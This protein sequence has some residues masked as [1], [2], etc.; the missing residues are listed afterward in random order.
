MH[1]LSFDSI[2][3]C[4]LSVSYIYNPWT[5]RSSDELKD[6]FCQDRDKEA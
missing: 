2:S 5:W 4:T 1:R 6:D 3:N